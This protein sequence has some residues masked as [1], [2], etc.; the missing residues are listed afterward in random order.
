MN[1]RVGLQMYTFSGIYLKMLTHKSSSVSNEKLFYADLRNY[2]VHVE[3]RHDCVESRLQNHWSQA[4]RC[5]QV[6][7]DRSEQS[8]LGK[9]PMTDQPF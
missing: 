8:Q 2:S 7:A 3:W 9:K 6:Q 4:R 5:V 1:V